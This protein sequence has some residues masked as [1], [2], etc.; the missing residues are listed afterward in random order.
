MPTDQEIQ[1]M[2]N[3]LVEQRNLAHNQLVQLQ[4]TV[5]KLQREVTALREVKIEIPQPLESEMSKSGKG[6]QH[7]IHGGLSSSAAPQHDASRTIKN[8]RSVNDGAI[9]D[10]VAT[11][12]STGKDGGKLK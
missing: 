10:S 4:A 3:A 2:L 11:V 6:S 12:S 7:T 8:G 1:D 9:R 5:A